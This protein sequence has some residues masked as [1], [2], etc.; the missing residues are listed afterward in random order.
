MSAPANFECSTVMI[1]GELQGQW[2]FYVSKRD[3][4][5]RHG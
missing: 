1:D 3:V 4:Y 5:K 2:P